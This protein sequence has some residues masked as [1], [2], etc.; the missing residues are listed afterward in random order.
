M[1]AVHARLSLKAKKRLTRN[2]GCDIII[3]CQY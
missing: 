3:K 2:V 1:M